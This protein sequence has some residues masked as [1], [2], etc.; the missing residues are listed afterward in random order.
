M[1]AQDEAVVS[2]TKSALVETVKELVRDAVCSVVLHVAFV[3]CTN[4]ETPH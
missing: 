3:F 2:A 4:Q 1:S